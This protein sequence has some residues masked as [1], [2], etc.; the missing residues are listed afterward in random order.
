VEKEVVVESIVHVDHLCHRYGDHLAVDNL[1]FD[2]RPGEVLGLLGPNGAGKT[3]TVR[4][5]NGLL[6]PA[7]GEVSVLGLDPFAQ[8]SRLRSQTGVLTETPALYERLT[9]RQNLTFFGTLA[10]MDDDALRRRIAE[11]LDFFEL[12]ERADQRITTYSKGMKQRLAL[13]RAL[14]HRPQVLF[15]DEPTSGLDPEASQ[16][17]H[18]LVESICQ[19]NGQTVLLC[20]HNLHEAERLCDRLVI[21]DRGRL[22]AFGS[23]DELRRQLLPGLWV[24]VELLRPL[25]PSSKLQIAALPGVVQV[26]M[27]DELHWL[28]H[29]EGESVV[30]S[31][32]VCLVSLQAAL[33]SLTPRQVSLQEIYFQVQR[34]N[35]NEKNEVPNEY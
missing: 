31:L 13:V 8:G 32:A 16:M 35:Q 25:P 29:V 12:S 20:T 14:L 5:L 18:E 19:E 11:L 4:V 6:S 27:E 23:L 24:A 1:S 22:L 2:A 10:G 15:L 30:P 33:L 9:A 26:K 21:L 17:V 34:Q 28:I 7:S 3:T